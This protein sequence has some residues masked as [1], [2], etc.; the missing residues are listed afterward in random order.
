ME[1]YYIPVL[2]ALL[3]VIQGCSNFRSE[4]R[5][6]K[7]DSLVLVEE[8]KDQV[9]V[10]AGIMATKTVFAD[11]GFTVLWE[12]ADKIGIWYT[13]K[14]TYSGGHDSYGFRSYSL[15]SGAGSPD[16]LF[17][18]TK[19]KS[20]EVY[21]GAFHPCPQ[22]LNYSVTDNGDI[23]L[24]MDLSSDQ[25]QASGAIAL[26]NYD[27][28]V[29]ASFE[30]KSTTSGSASYKISFQQKTA[31]LRFCIKPTAGMLS[32]GE[33]VK[34]LTLVA[35]NSAIAGKFTMNISDADAD[36]VPDDDTGSHRVTVY[37]DREVSADGISIPMFIIPSVRE[38]DA[39][40]IS[41]S[42]ESRMFA[43]KAKAAKDFQSGY[44]Y[45]MTVNLPA[46]EKE[47]LLKT[48]DL[49]VPFL[50]YSEIGAYDLSQ[51]SGAQPVITSIATLGDGWQYSYNSKTARIQNWKN[52][53]M[54]LIEHP[55]SMGEGNDVS[56]NVTTYGQGL[57]K[58]TQ[59]KVQATVMKSDSGNYWLV[60]EDGK[61]GYIIR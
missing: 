21:N 6:G 47:G 46:L 51:A 50:S 5:Y 8:E 25:K 11:D 42:T 19:L 33:N 28:K 59:G 57:S 38:N 54:I 17:T 35:D 26:S 18:G 37:T 4:E 10:S 16:G 22:N 36:L 20:T 1:K 23:L 32:L 41:I 43:F 24:S 27:F 48:Y 39:L 29:A 60:S 61:T 7:D 56:L 2:A 14:T 34:K 53:S 3:T 30:D 15:K 58:I 55:A 52:K 44:S 49:T 9:A 40:N 13:T 45:S 12:S 31:V